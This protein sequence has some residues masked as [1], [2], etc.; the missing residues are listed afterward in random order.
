MKSNLYII[1]YLFSNIFRTFDVYLFYETF[2]TDEKKRKEKKYC[3][4][5]YFLV[6]SVEYIW[7]D[8][9]IL[10]LLLNVVGLLLLTF[11]YSSNMKKRFLGAGFIL[12]L[13]M[14]T[15]ALVISLTGYLSFSLFQKGFF[16]SLGGVV[17][18]PIVS[19]LFIMV[20]RKLKKDK[21]DIAVPLSYW[22]T[23]IVVPVACIY[24]I[25]MGFSIERIQTWQLL[26]LVII[27][28][29]ITLSVFLLYEKQIEFFQEENRKN[30][31]E[32]Q[33][34]YYHKQ[35]DAMMKME[36]ATKSLR[37]D[38]KNHLLTIDALAKQGA[39]EKIHHY[40]KDLQSF[41]RPV[42]RYFSTGNIVIDSILNSKLLEAQEKGIEMD[43]KV[44]IPEK[45]P[46]G[47][48]DCTILLGNLLDNAIENA[49]DRIQ[50]IFRYDR[51]RLMLQCE[52]EYQGKRKR[53]GGEYSSSK[54]DYKNHGFGIHNMKNV[55][56]KYDGRM[57]VRDTNQI[58][59]VDILFYL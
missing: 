27:I 55:V 43:V 35:F 56:S 36:N 46:L 15:E 6:I 32:A 5:A 20:Y 25:A 44:A 21:F 40:V 8:I 12:A 23:V 13:L 7:L 2:L 26:S 29:L 31:L 24:L 50:F 54:P 1:L 49:K 53:H 34:Q 33:N 19:F 42:E 41:S 10:T 17:C 11:L 18:I 9:P 3:Y 30:M 59:K 58:F 14:A 28:F 22:I 45:L 16:S 51:G 47:D 57:V 39:V 37:H 48:M 38:M 4:I 52:N